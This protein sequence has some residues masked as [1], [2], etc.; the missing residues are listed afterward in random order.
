MKCAVAGCGGTPTVLAKAQASPFGI[1]T[2]GIAVYWTN[3][4]DGTVMKCATTGCG[5]AP[6]TIASSQKEPMGI[7]VDGTSVYWANHN[8]LD[9]QKVP[10]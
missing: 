4:G 9:I 6:T 7:A 1:A 8:G 2:D 3:E 5:G 10:K